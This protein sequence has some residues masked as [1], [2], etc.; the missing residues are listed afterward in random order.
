MASF[1]TKIEDISKEWIAGI[2]ELE[3]EAFTSFEIEVPGERRGYGS[4]IGF[5]RMTTNTSD[6][7]STL[8]VKV[9]RT[10][11]A[12][13]E[14]IRRFG[15]F[16]REA[17]F[18]KSIAPKTPTRTP[19]LYAVEYDEESGDAIIVLEDCSRMYKIPNQHIGWVEQ[20]TE[21]VSAAARLHAHWWNR[22][23]E[24][25][26]FES[27]MRP[28]EEYWQSLARRTGE[29]W[30]RWL[31]SPWI[32]HAPASLIPSC[33]SLVERSEPFMTTCW[34]TTDLTLCHGDINGANLFH[35]PENPQDPIVVIDWTSCHLGR[36][37][38]DIA[39]L[40]S[41]LPIGFRR[42]EEVDLV[43][44]YHEVLE[45]SAYATHW[46]TCYR[47]TGSAVCST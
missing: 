44:R 42:S 14:V 32:E 26:R 16:R 41:Q 34:P 8:V 23:T 37:A 21:I 46:R 39:Y 22:E 3:P 29:G 13:A 36:G 4:E 38:H 31:D 20:L 47:I 43:S 17:E 40:L 1:P 27:V 25:A 12:A 28:G 11:P 10:D 18:Y 9:P 45:Q 19:K 2:F 24:I 5:L 15:S 30:A 35:D 7:P 6:V 33:R